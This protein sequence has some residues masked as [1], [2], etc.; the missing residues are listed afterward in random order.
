M[1]AGG[2][3]KMSGAMVIY[4][5]TGIAIVL[6]SNDGCSETQ[7]QLHDIAVSIRKVQ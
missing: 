3:Y 5:E 4:L 7:S 1:A 6:L 2:V